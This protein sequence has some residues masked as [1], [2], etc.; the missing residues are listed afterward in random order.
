MSHKTNSN[1]PDSGTPTT[2]WI[3]RGLLATVVLVAMVYGA[4]FF[5]ANVLNDSPD[6]LDANDLSEALATTEPE[7]PDA[8][9]PVTEA[10]KEPADTV[11]DVAGFDGVWTPTT[12]SEFGYRVDE[13]LG[14]VNVTAVGR[15]NEIAG[16]LTIEGTTASVTAT[17]EVENI[18][19]N[20]SIRDGQFR[21]RIMD[22][23]NFPTANFRTTEPIDFG[24]LPADGEQVTAI[25]NGELTLKG[26][27]LAV[28]V[29]ITA[30][31]SG[32]G[33]GVLG[34]IPITFTDYGIDNPSNPG[35]SLEDEGVVEF[36]L[37]FERA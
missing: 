25:A 29:E 21:G 34:N 32:A 9:M 33:I 31:A 22:V 35:V 14:G 19:S 24:T 10:S 23:S 20:D 1:T 3:K 26:V 16:S 28:A 7:A 5:Y 8:G 4:I 11:V 27:T 13:V 37:V 6:A 17:V 15:S 2:K 36:V 30:Q 12:A 18:V